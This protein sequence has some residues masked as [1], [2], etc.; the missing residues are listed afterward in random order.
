ME[1]ILQTGLWRWVKSTGLDRLELVRLPE[2]WMLRGTILL[3]GESGP[4]EARYEVVC[5]EE[6]NTKRAHVSLRDGT[7]ERAIQVAVEDGKWYVNGHANNSVA[8][9]MDI[10]LEWSPSTNT[11]PIRRLRLPIG[12]TSGPLIAAWVRFPDLT[13]QPLPQEYERIS[14][15][16]YR[17]NSNGGKFVAEIVVDAEGLVLNYEGLW[18]RTG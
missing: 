3:S 5:D 4:A 10:D 17:Y 11:I 2:E 7:D 8:E 18:R 1:H 12:E 16:H 15:F 13:L 9:C 14:E 6:W